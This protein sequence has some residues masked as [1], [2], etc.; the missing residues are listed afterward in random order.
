MSQNILS[1][2]KEYHLAHDRVLW[3]PLMNTLINL[4]VL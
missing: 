4:G 3:R 1:I 2:L